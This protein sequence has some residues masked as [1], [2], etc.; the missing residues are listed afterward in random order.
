MAGYA[1]MTKSTVPNPQWLKSASWLP[2]VATSVIA[3]SQS[4]LTSIMQ[5]LKNEV[6]P[7]EIRCTFKSLYLTCE[8][9]QTTIF[10][11]QGASRWELFRPYH[12]LQAHLQ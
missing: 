3:F 7:T 2:L 5:I 4:F 10:I 1:H 9:M 6:F 11:F 8:A 12:I